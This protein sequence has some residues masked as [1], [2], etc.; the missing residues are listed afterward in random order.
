[1]FCAEDP[2][3][4][5]RFYEIQ[6]SAT[7]AGAGLS[8]KAS[9]NIIIVPTDDSLDKENQNTRIAAEVQETMRDQISKSVGRYDIA[10]LT[11]EWEKSLAN[12][13]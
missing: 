1:M 6:V 10:S 8:G 4:P 13:P 5:V 3:T 2:G 7:D 12:L 11:V 9:C